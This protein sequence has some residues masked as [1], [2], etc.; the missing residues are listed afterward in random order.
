MQRCILDRAIEEA[1]NQLGFNELKDKQLE[2]IVSFVGGQDT[3]VLLPTGYG[4]SVIYSMLPVVFDK[5]KGLQYE[6]KLYKYDTNS[7]T[8]V[9]IAE[10]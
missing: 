9:T 1:R 4:K 2:A 6:C 10:L 8:S 7:L 5:L 3:F